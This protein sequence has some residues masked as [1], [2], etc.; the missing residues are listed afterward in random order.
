[1]LKARASAMNP[2]PYASNGRMSVRRDGRALVDTYDVVDDDPL[3][4]GYAT[5]IR[6]PGIGARLR[7]PFPT[8]RRSA[9]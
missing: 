3:P 2:D 5:I 6:P 9:C 4:D 7:P 1:M 8:S